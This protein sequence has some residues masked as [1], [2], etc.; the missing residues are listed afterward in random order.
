MGPFWIFLMG[1]C[2]NLAVALWAV[3]FSEDALRTNEEVV[4]GLP[5][6]IPMHP[7][8]GRYDDTIQRGLEAVELYRKLVETDPGRG[9]TSDLAT[10]LHN[11]GVHLQAVG[12]NTEALQV[13]QEP[14]DLRLKLGEVNPVAARDLAP[15]LNG[16]GIHLSKAGRQGDALRRYEEAVQLRRKLASQ[17]PSATKAL[18]L[19][20]ITL[21]KQ[22]RVM[23]RHGD[24]FHA[25]EEAV[26]L[27]RKLVA[28][29]PGVTSELAQSLEHLAQD[30]CAVDRREEAVRTGE[31]L[32]GLCRKLAETHTSVHVTMDL[33]FSLYYLGVF[34]I[35]VGRPGDA[36]HADEEAA[37]LRRKLP[38]TETDLAFALDLFLA[39]NDLCLALKRLDRH[40]EA[41]R[42]AEDLVGISRNPFL[43]SSRSGSYGPLR[44][45]EERVE[46][47]RRAAAMCS[48][49]SDD[50]A[51]SLDLLG[52]YLRQQGHKEDALLAC[53]EA[54]ELRRNLQKTGTK[55]VLSLANSLENLGVLLR[56][57]GWHEDLLSMAQEAVDL[58]RRL[59]ATDR[60]LTDLLIHSP[61][62]LIMSGLAHSLE[63]LAFSLSA[64][65]DV[66]DAVHAAG[67]SV[68]LYRRRLPDR[69]EESEAGLANALCS[70]AAFLRAVDRHYASRADK[71]GA[72]IYR[73]LA[74]THPELAARAFRA[75]ARDFRSVG[76][77]EDA[78]HAE[79]QSAHLYRTVTQAKPALLGLRIKSL[80]S[81]AEDLRVL[82]ARRGR[83]A[84]RCRAG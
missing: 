78:L 26:G 65:G 62:N 37:Q 21:G 49:P 75:S 56:A 7:R 4:V 61:K 72:D 25:D 55:P 20:L 33:I 5:P 36:L 27:R 59:I 67:E 1:I 10:L 82:G 73:N 81:L 16:L 84:Y 14:V 35:A 17:D 77:R 58:Q 31:E 52:V 71:E 50:L 46:I 66:E 44:V 28:A 18:A 64:V 40:E 54:V 74:K 79:G 9:H 8:M 57:L 12:R 69:T 2:V 29:D 23:G 13:G 24:A 70:L 60:D 3:G 63:N 53:E 22:L 38:A 42:F 30:L 6:M 83:G 15:A 76:L 11:L 43:G 80:Q 45:G 51:S 68:D 41:I 34:F 47:C 19:S 32:T 48:T 39:L